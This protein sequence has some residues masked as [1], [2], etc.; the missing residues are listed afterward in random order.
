[1]KTH[2]VKGAEIIQHVKFLAPV[3]SLV[4]HDH[5]RWDGNGYPDRL[6]GEEIPQGARIVALV[7]AYDAMTTDR[8][9]RKAPG[10][11]YAI[12]ELKKYAGSQFDP[13]LVELFLS[14]LKDDKKNGNA[15]GWRSGE[16][17]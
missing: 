1:M 6:K 4:R 8:V 11:E 15:N 10:K 14:V 2:P 7:D 13:I 16:N 17:G 9:Y 3:V 12:S 5:E